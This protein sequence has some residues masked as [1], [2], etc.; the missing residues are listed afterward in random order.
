MNNSQDRVLA[1]KLLSRWQQDGSLP[2]DNPAWT[3]ASALT[4]EIVWGCL[5]HK[6]SLDAWMDHLSQRPPSPELRPLLAMGLYQVLLLDG[7]ADH[8]AANETLQAARHEHIPTPLIGYANAL[9][10]RAT[11]ERESLHTWLSQQ[12]APQRFSHPDLLVRRWTERFG[13]AKTEA[14]LRWNQERSVTFARL[15]ALGRLHRADQEISS[16]CERNTAFPGFW[17]LPRGMS[18]VDLPGF[19]EGHWYVQDP[20]TSLAPALLDAKPGETILDP[21]AAPGGKAI[22]LAE[23]LGHAGTGLTASDPN[24][25]RIPRLRENLERLGMSS[26]Q[27]QQGD[28]SSNTEAYDAILLDVPCSNTGVLQRRPDARWHFTRS[29]VNQL[30]VLQGNLLDHAAEHLKPGGRIVYSTCSIEAEETTLQISRWLQRHPNWKL[31]QETLLLPGEKG[32]DG[33]YAA[34]LESCAQDPV[35]NV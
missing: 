17:K 8:A 14:I 16:D 10:R 19:P 1:L 3:T 26:V 21:C 29:F 25:K 27:V 12:P 4:R 5:R 6:G 30:V 9:L 22:L 32:C 24:P 33:A 7:I 18:P 23:S 13:P 15:T 2:E 31:T 35:S 20:S 11:R 28:L 34:R